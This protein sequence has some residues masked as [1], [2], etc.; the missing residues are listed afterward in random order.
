MS[1]RNRRVADLDARKGYHRG[2]NKKKFH[3]RDMNNFPDPTP[4]QH[5]AI[6]AYAEGYHLYLTGSAGTG[7]T[8]LAIDLALRDVLSRSTDARRVVIVRSIV[9]TRDIGFLPGTEDEKQAIYEAPYKA[10]CD[11]IFPYSKSY[12]NLKKNGYMDFISSSFVR[13]ITLRDSVVIV[14]EAQNYTFEEINSVMTRLGSG[15]RI[16]FTGDSVQNDLYRKRG[17]ESGYI[18]FES[19]IECLDEFRIVRFTTDDIVRSS[20]VR[21]YLIAKE[22]LNL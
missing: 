17:D 4:K 15:S 11:E 1:K 7:K 5:D 19:I 20:I 14:E 8:A 16:I 10:I 9:P 6:R 18:K 22:K 21:N 13:G 12:E 3:I 2:E